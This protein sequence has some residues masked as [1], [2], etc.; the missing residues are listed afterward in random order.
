MLPMI[1][2]GAY[3]REEIVKI[4]MSP[5]YNHKVKKRP[6]REGDRVRPKMEATEKGP[7]QRKVTPNWEGPHMVTEEVCLGPFRL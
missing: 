1:R 4:R 2:G 6:L 5:F 3:L 7:I